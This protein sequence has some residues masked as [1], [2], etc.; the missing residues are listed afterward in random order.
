M[1]KVEQFADCFYHALT[2]LLNNP[3]K[4]V[5]NV[6]TVPCSKVCHS[7]KWWKLI[8]ALTSVR[9]AYTKK[10]LPNVLQRPEAFTTM[11]VSVLS[12]SGDVHSSKDM[13]LWAKDYLCFLV[14]LA[15]II[16]C[17]ATG[18]RQRLPKFWCS[19]KAASLKETKALGR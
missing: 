7:R 17:N 1:Y 9:R 8:C 18:P 2:F 11:Q 15:G 5:Y 19:P 12:I 14:A 6:L 13:L 3:S 4:T 16:P 10:C